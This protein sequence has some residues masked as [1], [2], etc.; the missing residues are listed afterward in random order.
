MSTDRT[1]PMPL[2]RHRTRDLLH[3]QRETIRTALLLARPELAGRLEEGPSGAVVIPLEHGRAVE[4]GRMRRSG[5]ARW[6]VVWPEGGRA[7]MHEAGG[8]HEAARAALVAL[9][10]SR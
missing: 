7:R 1:S 6:V 2:G 5:A 3:R 4:I 8:A 10:R 9:E